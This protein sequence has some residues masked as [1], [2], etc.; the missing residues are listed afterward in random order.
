MWA[1]TIILILKGIMKSKNA[2]ILLNKN[3][4]FKINTKRIR[5]WKIPHTVLER[6]ILCFSSHKNRKLRLKL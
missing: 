2:C 1:F 4:N 5:K 3:M 6:Q